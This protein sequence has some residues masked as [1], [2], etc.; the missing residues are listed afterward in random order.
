MPRPSCQPLHRQF[1]VS[2]LIREHIAPSLSIKLDSSRF[3]DILTRHHLAGAWLNFERQF[4][5]D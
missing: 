1:A 5:T 3:Q 4:L 2:H